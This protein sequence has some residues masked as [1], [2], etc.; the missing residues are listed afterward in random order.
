M[1]RVK[2]KPELFAWARERSRLSADHLAAKFPSLERWQSGDL[3][4]TLKQA[5]DFA[6]TTHVPVGFLFL[7]APP[8][9]PLPIPDF[10]TMAGREV[11]R[12]SPDLLEVIYACQQRQDWFQDHARLTGQGALAFVGSATLQSNIEQ[13]AADIRRA[14]GF[15]LGA[16]ARCPRWEDA[17]RAMVSQADAIGVLVMTSGIVASNTH[18][19]LDTNEFR[20]FALVDPLAPLIFINGADSKSAQMFTLAHELAHVWLG[21]TALSDTTVASRQQN[22]T[23]TWCNRIAAEMLAPLEVVR[24]DLHPGEPL[25]KTVQRF[26]RR[27]KVSSL[28]VLQRLRDAQ[29]LTGPNFESAYREELERLANLPRREGGGDFYVNT[30]ARYSRRF[31][32]A[33]VESTLEGRTLYRDAMRMLGISKTE[34]FHELGRNVAFV[35]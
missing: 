23:E 3:D 33:L 2:I 11:R 8:D 22:A 15:D 18:R 27:F 14:L 35:G 25:A 1:T 10:R 24:A 12:P 6:K 4:P 28:V 21:Q 16:R 32:R 20:G 31:A 30:T 5:E 19:R 9:E 17:L 7:P 34:T 29:H 26:G 13:T